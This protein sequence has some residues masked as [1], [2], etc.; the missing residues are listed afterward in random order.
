MTIEKVCFV[1]PYD[2]KAVRITCNDCG[3]CT[4][5]PLGE[6]RNISVLVERNCVMCG[7]STGVNRETAEYRTMLLFAETL[8]KLAE[9]TSG[10]NIEFSMQIGC[11]E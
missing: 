8:G 1:H 9:A 5:V 3:C 10:R 2:I 4:V 6:L 7:K 11:P